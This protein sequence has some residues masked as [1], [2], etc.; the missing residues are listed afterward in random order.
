MFLDNERML[1]YVQKHNICAKLL[2]PMT[3]WT[4]SA[5]G[6]FHGSYKLP[7]ATAA[8]IH[9]YRNNHSLKPHKTT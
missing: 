5:K 8:D 3:K 6:Y 9:I 7:H 1:N 4:Q 2:H